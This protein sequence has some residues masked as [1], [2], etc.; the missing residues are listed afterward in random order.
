MKKI[1]LFI[2][3][4]NLALNSKVKISDGDFEYL[5]RVMRHKVGDEILL[6]NGVDGEFVA[7]IA[8]VEK[9]FND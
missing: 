1:R 7:V 3:E 6:F 9:R 4:K 2:E 5:T 8:Q